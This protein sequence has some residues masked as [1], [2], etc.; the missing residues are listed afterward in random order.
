MKVLLAIKPEYAEK[1]F[2]GIKK[3]EFRKTVFKD[4]SVRKVVVYASSPVKRV[5]GEFEIDE[6]ITLEKE[7]LWKETHEFAGISKTIFDNYFRKKELAHAIRIKTTKK[8]KTPL[9]L[10]LDFKIRSA[11]QSFIYINSN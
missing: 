7:S 9:Y 11:P 2:A 4:K 1:I 5:V 6:I 8:Y 3:F 10:D